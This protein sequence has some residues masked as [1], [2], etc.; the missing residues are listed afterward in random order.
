MY[1]FTSSC[2]D[3]QAEVRPALSMESANDVELS[4]RIVLCRV[5]L[6]IRLMVVSY[7]TTRTFC[8]FLN[9]S[10]ETLCAFLVNKHCILEYL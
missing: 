8:Y 4:L 2:I 1:L 5:W 10:R 9:R 6:F 7:D 3:A